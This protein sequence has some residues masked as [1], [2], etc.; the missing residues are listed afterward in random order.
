MRISQS[1]AENN[2]DWKNNS[3]CS[4]FEKDYQINKI[5]HIIVQFLPGFVECAAVTAKWLTY[6]GAQGIA[7]AVNG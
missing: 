7:S 5:K 4:H 3:R 2:S 6:I 1:G